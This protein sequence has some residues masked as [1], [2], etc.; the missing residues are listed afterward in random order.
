MSPKR[1]EVWRAD[2]GMGGKVRPI[3]IIS[4]IDTDPPRK[5][6]IYI[7]ITTQNRGSKYEVTLP[8]RAFLTEGSTANVQGIGSD[9]MADESFFLKKL[10]D[11]PESAMKEIEQALLFAVGMAD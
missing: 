5:L 1:G 7:P 8:R 3:I 9:N 6:A 2:F 11:L 4:R 10:G